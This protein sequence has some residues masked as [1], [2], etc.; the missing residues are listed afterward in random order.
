MQGAYGNVVVVDHGEGDSTLYAHLS[1][2]DVLQGQRVL[3]GQTIGALGATGRV[4]GPHLHFEFIEDGVHKDP[5]AAVRRN[6]A[7]ELSAQAKAEFDRLAQSV[8]AQFA[9]VAN[10]TVVASAQ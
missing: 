6:Q 4:T 5:I 1:R 8:R 3:R 10:A 7:P 2:I 9:T